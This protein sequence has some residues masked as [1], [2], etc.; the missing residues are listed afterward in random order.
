[1]KINRK[2]W[3]E[4]AAF[5]PLWMSDTLRRKISSAGD[6]E[7]CL[8]DRHVMTKEAGEDGYLWVLGPGEEWGRIKT[9]KLFHQEILDAIA[10]RERTP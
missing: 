8:G 10:F 6:I 4:R 7:F 1:M 3:F 9:T 5:A 2:L